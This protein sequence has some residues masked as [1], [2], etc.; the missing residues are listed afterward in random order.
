MNSKDVGERIMKLRKQKGYTQAN[1]AERL[2]VSNK[3]VS[4]WETGDGFPE[5]S[6]L[7]NLAQ[8]LDTTVDML[9]QE[10]ST[11]YKEIQNQWHG[12]KPDVLVFFEVLLIYECVCL[13]ISF[14]LSLLGTDFWSADE[15]IVRAFTI[16]RI[17]LFLI[18][19]IIECIQCKRYGETKAFNEKLMLKV[20]IMA[21]LTMSLYQI[22]IRIAW[23]SLMNSAIQ[24]STDQQGN[25]DLLIIFGIE[26]VRMLLICIC[27]FI[28]KETLKT[29]KANICFYVLCFIS[30]ADICIHLVML[31]IDAHLVCGFLDMP[32]ICTIYLGSIVAILRRER[33]EKRN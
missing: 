11:D 25:K 8:E 20:W 1:L 22:C 29:K 13:C 14:I 18:V 7:P 31:W 26:V 10:D 19:M 28:T 9:L 15:S 33:N 30:A 16:A 3:T 23:T 5:I 2:N 12:E 27:G 21:L 17:G 6:M 4:R 32:I 24:T